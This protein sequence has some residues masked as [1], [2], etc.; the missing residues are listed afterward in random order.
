VGV[1]PLDADVMPRKSTSTVE[2]LSDQRSRHLQ[3][4]GRDA[5]L[6]PQL[7]TDSTARREMGRK[8]RLT[9]IYCSVTSLDKCPPSRGRTSSVRTPSAKVTKP[10][11]GF[12]S[13]CHRHRQVRRRSCRSRRGGDGV[14]G[15]EAS[16]CATFGSRTSHASRRGQQRIQE[17]Q[18][19]HSP[20]Q[21]VPCDHV[22]TP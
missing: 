4:S 9:W 8:G 3:P 17:G 16:V 20:S 1:F 2:S 19:T 14:S 7:G 10:L 22:Y 13:T 21:R 18:L 5:R 15:R 6:K 11:I 12:P